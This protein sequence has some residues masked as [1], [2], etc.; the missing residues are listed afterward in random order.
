M[1][2][3]GEDH[4]HKHTRSLPPSCTPSPH[5][6]AT[7]AAP[8]PRTAPLA[9][10][11]PRSPPPRYPPAPRLPRAPCAPGSKFAPGNHPKGGRRL[12]LGG[13]R[14]KLKRRTSQSLEKHFPTRLSRPAG[15]VK[16]LLFPQ[17]Q[18]ERF[19]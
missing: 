16:V 3:G 4:T 19:G 1:G 15:L 2:G 7:Q 14:I 11:R 17:W 6:P 5:L 13:E 8:G 10:T 9:P 12:V 18:Y